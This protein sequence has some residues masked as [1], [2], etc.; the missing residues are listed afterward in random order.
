LEKSFRF[1]Y[2]RVEKVTTTPD[3][4]S[5]GFIHVEYPEPHGAR[6]RQILAAHP[7]V[8]QLF[9]NTPSTFGWILG[10]VALQVLVAFGVAG[11]PWWVI[12]FVAYTV[13]ATANHALFV[14]IHDCTHNLVFKGSNAN[15]LAGIV[16]NLPIVFPSAIGFRAYHLIHHRRQGEL[17]YDADIAGPLEAKIFSGST[18]T[19]TFWLLFF[20]VFE[21]FVRP[22]R[23]KKVKMLEP[24]MLLN[25]MVELVFLAVIAYF[26]GWWALAYLTL[27]TIFSIGLHPLGARWIQEHYVVHEHQETYSYYGPLNTLMFNVGYHNEHH[28]LMVIPWSRLPKLKAMAP[29]FYEPLYAHRSYVKLLW[30]FLFDPRLN[31]FSR[32]I[33]ETKHAATA[34]AIVEQSPLP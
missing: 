21:G 32:V 18:F 5:T 7:E 6:T 25:T 17:D 23:V 14:M 13:G 19:K 20:F 29:E 1:D 2:S 33:R 27:A 31:L 9:G 3:P 16:S 34:A 8:R 24:W 26:A 15:K 4:S 10:L 30:M 12:L 22:A 28:D 11:M